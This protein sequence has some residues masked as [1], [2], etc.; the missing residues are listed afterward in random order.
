MLSI[1]KIGVFNPAIAVKVGDVECAWPAWQR[2][3]S[4]RP[5]ISWSRKP[6]RHIAF[7]LWRGN[8]EPAGNLFTLLHPIP[9]P[10]QDLTRYVYN[11][12]TKLDDRN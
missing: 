6:D 3:T 9:P 12:S 4:A 5:R 8:P 1:K 10:A 2:S 11:G 7:A